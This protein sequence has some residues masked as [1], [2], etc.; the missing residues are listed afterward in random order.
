MYVGIFFGLSMLVRLVWPC[1]MYVGIFFGLSTLVCLVWPCAMYV[2]IS[3]SLSTAMFLCMLV[4]K[5]T[6]ITL[7]HLV[8]LRLLPF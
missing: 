6:L 2:G 7:I 4:F 3:S 1:F 5:F 8:L